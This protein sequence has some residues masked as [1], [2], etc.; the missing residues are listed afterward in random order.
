MVHGVDRENEGPEDDRDGRTRTA[1][2]SNAGE[3]APGFPPGGLSLAHPRRAEAQRT[4][5]LERAVS[6]RQAVDDGQFP[7]A[8]RREPGREVQVERGLRGRGG[9]AR[10]EGACPVHV[11]L[12]AVALPQ[13]VLPVEYVLLAA[14]PAL[15]ATAVDAVPTLGA[16]DGD[17]CHGPRRHILNPAALGE[18]L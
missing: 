8:A 1:G 5:R 16:A 4:G 13:A 17:P 6:L 15:A 11:V 2:L 14:T 18:V 10:V 7:R 3:A 12:Q 9:V